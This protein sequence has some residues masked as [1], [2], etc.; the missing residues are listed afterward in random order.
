MSKK[1]DMLALFTRHGLG[2]EDLITEACLQIIAGADTT[3][4]SLRGIMLYVL[5]YLWVY[6][7]L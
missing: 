2:K 6:M 4:T 1:L 3:A 7:K 5:S